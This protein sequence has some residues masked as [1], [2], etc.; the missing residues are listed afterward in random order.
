MDL[1]TIGAVF[2][3]AVLVTIVSFWLH[4]RLAGTQGRPGPFSMAAFVL[5][6]LSVLTALLTGAFLLVVALR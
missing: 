1:Q 3:G 6:W 2:I 5:G 4:A